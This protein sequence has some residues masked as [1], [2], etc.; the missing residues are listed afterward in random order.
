MNKQIALIIKCIMLGLV[1][2]LFVIGCSTENNP[3]ANPVAPAAGQPTSSPAPSPYP[4]LT[5]E[6]IAN[7]IPGYQVLKVDERAYHGE[8]LLDDQTASRIRY[9]VGGSVNHRNNGVE[10]G[11]WQ[12]WEDQT[13]T[14]STPNPGSA[15]VD[16]YPHPYRFN[17]CIRMWLDLTHVQLPPGVRWDQVR[18]YYQE[19]NGRLTQYW[20]QLDL[21]AHRYYAWPDHFSRYI[22]TAPIA[23]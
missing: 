18:F 10:I 16:F 4:V 11:A 14:V 23:G 20:G 1:V 9:Q 3:V 21:A 19:E 8:G 12:L 2:A 6:Q 13:V 15:I 17:G 22:I 7:L 5:D